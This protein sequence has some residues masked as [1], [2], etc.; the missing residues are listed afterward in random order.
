MTIQQAIDYCTILQDKY[1]SP[2]VIDDEWLNY[3]N[4]GINEY[5][6]RLVPDSEG[7]VVNYEMDKNTINN[8]KPLIYPVTVQMDSDGLVTDAAITGALQT[9]GAES[10]ASWFRVMS[11]GFTVSGYP[12]RYVRQ[13]NL[14]PF[15]KNYF[16]QPTLTSARYTT[17]A[18]GLSFEPVATS[19]DITLTVIKRPRILSLSPVVD[20]EFDDY[21]MYNVIMIA[22]Q[23][24]GVAT[25][26]EEII[27]DI[28]NISVQAK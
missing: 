1:G 26:D 19:T 14:F 11:L 28:K 23:L 20:P 15:K 16:K 6:N 7:G 12:I 10:G 5:L 27:S 25:R 13:N 4:H 9:E 24:A 8:L 18:K 22:L 17:I 21:A 3:L 2:N